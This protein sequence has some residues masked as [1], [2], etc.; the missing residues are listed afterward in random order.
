LFRLQ[1][2]GSL[3]LTRL[4]GAAVLSVVAQPKRLALLAYLAAG[5]DRS[6]SRDELSRVFWP[7]SDRDDARN[8]LRQTLHRLRRS[9]A[10]GV[11][12]S[13]GDRE[14][15]IDPEMLQ[16]DVV[17]FEQSIESGDLQLALELYRGHL[18]TDLRVSG[19]PELDHWQDQRS[20][21]LRKSAVEAAATL[22][23]RKEDEG[24]LP[25]AIEFARRA[26]KLAPFDEL[27]IQTLMRLLASYGDRAGAVAAFE[28]FAVRFRSELELEAS[29]Q[30]LALL[31][32]IRSDERPAESPTPA[33]TPARSDV[34]PRP[35]T[36]TGIRPLPVDPPRTP[37]RAALAWGIGASVVLT[38][39]VLVASALD[40]PRPD[41]IHFPVRLGQGAEIYLGAGTAWGRPLRTSIALSPDGSLLVYSAGIGQGGPRPHEESRLYIER[42]GEGDP[43]PIAGTD[44]ARMPFFSPDGT[45]IAFLH[46]E[47]LKRVPV[48]GGVVET[49]TGRGGIAEG[50]HPLSATWGDDG[51]IVFANGPYLFRVAATGGQPEMLA[52]VDRSGRG[53]NRYAEPHMLPGSKVLLFHVTRSVQDPHQS[54]IVALDLETG[55][56]KTVLTDGMSPRYL[57]TGHLVFMRS[58]TLMAI[59]FDPRKIEAQGEPVIM[60]EDVVQ[61]LF[62]PNSNAETGAAQMAISASGH[63]AYASGG[64]YPDDLSAAVRITTDGDTIPLE[65]DSRPFIRFRVSPDGTRIAF[66]SGAGRDH[67]LGIHDLSRGVTQSLDTG[68]F[69]SL[70]PEWSPDGRSLIFGA[71]TR[72]NPLRLT[73][74]RMHV[75]GSGAPE[76][77]TASD[78]NQIPASWSSQGVIAYLEGGDIWVLP[79]DGEPAPFFTS[80]VREEYPTFSPDG[81][82]MAYNSRGGMYVRPYPGPGIATLI[83]DKGYSP[84]WSA[85]GRTLYYEEF[86]EQES[87]PATEGQSNGVHVLMSVDVVPGAE[88]QS[89]RP[90]LFFEPWPRG[91]AVSRGYDVLPDSSFVTAILVDTRPALERVGITELTV[92]LNW[93]EYLKERVGN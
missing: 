21:T 52:E 3:D 39:G 29:S 33:P 51:T 19:C 27:Q 82:W 76:R 41:V 4:D 66:Q 61:S 54:D 48:T 24:D 78:R 59:G 72:D 31:Q 30:T 53:E 86:R 17:D 50:G 91:M 89:S 40:R 88:F 83:T 65:M 49:I 47:S 35:S 16:C 70:Y 79:P 93:A 84:A 20:A 9:L 60:V 71:T 44:R 74:F 22:C 80:E 57:D 43:S 23:K 11:I 46:E 25:T 77:L 92:V 45:W 32:E 36:A 18:V 37:W 10:E 87:E 73:A 5:R 13:V 6:I 75:D 67:R 26:V 64:V 90:Q 7:E 28:A 34:G 62:M 12:V 8:A 58:G 38:F 15:A 56:R 42:L 68:P 85:D 55:T 1:L 81:A 2:L 14:V 63:L 69:T